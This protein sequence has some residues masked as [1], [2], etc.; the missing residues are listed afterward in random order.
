MNKPII[1]L[2]GVRTL[3]SASEERVER[4]REL[5]R[6]AKT[7]ASV[8]KRSFSALALA[9]ALLGAGTA[10]QAQ[11]P[12]EGIQVRLSGHIN[13]ALMHVDDGVEQDSFNVDSGNSSTRFRF[14]AEGPAGGGL[15]AGILFEAQ[16]QSNP[17]GAVT[18]AD[19]SIDAELQERHMDVFLTGGFGTVRLGQGDGAANGASE[20]D[21]SGT[22][23]AHY[24]SSPEIGGSFQYRTGGTLSGTSIGNSISNQDFASRYDRVLYQTPSFNGFMGEVSWGHKEDDIVELALRYSGKIGA[25]GTLAGAVGYSNIFL[26]EDAPVATTDD[27]VIGGSISWLHPSGLNLTYAH[28]T[29]DLPGRTGKFNYIKGGYKFGK[30]AVSVDY[31][32]GDDQAAA[33]D[34]AKVYGVGYVFIP[35]PWAEIF[36]LYKIHSLDRPGVSLEDISFAMIGTRVKF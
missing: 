14:T 7:L 23:L 28:T 5:H 1:E 21:L 11:A 36:A 2:A 19:R 32:M 6:T 27:K 15:R 33:G 18:F 26:S 9:M 20:V 35:I 24:S 34:E 4:W 8:K 22:S 13:R 10:A 30:H 17:S 25:L 16:F 29:R 3:F 31:G 12:A